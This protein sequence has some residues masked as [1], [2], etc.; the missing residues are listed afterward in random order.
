MH[1]DFFTLNLLS[2]TRIICRVTSSIITKAIVIT[3]TA[4]FTTITSAAV[5]YCH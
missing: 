4:T 1:F 5:N 2:H 3:R